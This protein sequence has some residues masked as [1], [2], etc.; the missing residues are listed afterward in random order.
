[1]WETKQISQIKVSQLDPD[2]VSLLPFVLYF[3]YLTGYIYEAKR[4]Q[5][6][7]CNASSFEISES[8]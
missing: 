3:T 7:I 6:S 8:N 1:M 2:K 5:F 4:L